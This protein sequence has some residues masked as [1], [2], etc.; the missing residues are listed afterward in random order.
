M[1]P[2]GGPVH[3]FI[4]EMFVKTGRS[5]TLKD[6][7]QE[8]ALSST[9]EAE[10]QVA[11]LERLGSI[12]RN[13]GDRQI[14]YAYP[15]SNEPT[16]HQVKITG[17]PQVYAL[18]A[19]DALGIPF[20]LKRDVEIH[21]AC[22]HCNRE[23]RIQVKSGRIAQQNPERMVVSYTKP[24]GCCVAAIEQCPHLNFFCS[25]EHLN[26][27]SVGQPEQ[28]IQMLTL[29]EALKGGRKAFET[30]LQEYTG[31]THESEALV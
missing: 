1:I 12:H 29:H 11:A 10:A 22:A 24:D 5:P 23:I 2:Q 14:T 26:Q 20:M 17:G 19:I 27:W 16:L 9:E 7:Q 6:I 25:A 30:L 3:R 4:L 21:S 31:G 18:C 15:F 28:T 13:L 8:F